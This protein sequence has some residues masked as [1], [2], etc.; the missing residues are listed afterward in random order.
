M[1]APNKFKWSYQDK[2][3]DQLWFDNIIDIYQDMGDTFIEFAHTCVR[4][5]LGWNPPD[6]IAVGDRCLA[7]WATPT[8]FV[9]KLEE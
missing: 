6:D 1:Q 4:I 2:L 9:F 7:Y 5:P 8:E 3:H